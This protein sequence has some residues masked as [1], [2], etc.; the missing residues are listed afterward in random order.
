MTAT[1]YTLSFDATPGTTIEL[2]NPI[3]NTIDLFEVP[4]NGKVVFY[5]GQTTLKPNERLS[6]H[7]T[8]VK[9]LAKGDRDKVYPI[10]QFCLLNNI[11]PEDIEITVLA[12]YQHTTISVE[13]RIIAAFT[14]QKYPMMNIGLTPEMTIRQQS[15][16]EM[17]AI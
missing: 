3:T 17:F 6:K 2:S 10:Y 11:A 15:G 9:K 1:I 16:R 12:T 5:A 13:R 4:A 7:R 8:Y 14:Q